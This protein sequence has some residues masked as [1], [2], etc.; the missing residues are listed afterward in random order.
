MPKPQP[1]EA[2]LRAAI[3]LEDLLAL[4]VKAGRLAPER[5]QDVAARARTLHSQVLKEKVGS[6]RSQAAARYEVSP[7]E[8]LVAAKVPSATDPR[9]L[10]DEDAIAECMAA[11]SDLP[12]LKIDPLKVDG[13]LV[14]KTLSRPFAR[15]H[16]RL[17]GTREEIVGKPRA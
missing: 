13:G 4:L 3:G 1:P 16:E 8:I 12:H 5:S 9:R 6:L 17:A 14:T 2:E 11:A 10:L 7:A 15:R